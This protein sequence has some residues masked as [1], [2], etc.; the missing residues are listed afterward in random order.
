MLLNSVCFNTHS[1]VS[2]DGKGSACNVGDLG[3]IPGLGRSPGGG[4][5]NPLQYSC[6]EKSHGRRSLAG[7]SPWG[8]KESDTTERL[9]FHVSTHTLLPLLMRPHTPPRGSLTILMKMAQSGRDLAE[10][11]ARAASF[12][13]CVPDFKSWRLITFLSQFSL[14]DKSRP[15]KMSQWGNWEMRRVASVV[16][17]GE[18][19]RP[20]WVPGGRWES[21]QPAH[22]SSPSF[23]GQ[24]AQSAPRP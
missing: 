19:P 6:L 3:S 7:C 22:S 8:R 12:K 10:T 14:E 16:T 11:K 17:L 9:H 4:N 21:A 23:T 5:G 2:S 18:L 15:E 20:S 24:E 1:C 13:V